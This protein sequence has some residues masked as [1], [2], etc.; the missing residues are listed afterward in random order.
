VSRVPVSVWVL[1][2]AQIV[3]SGVV[4]TDFVAVVDVGG[5]DVAFARGGSGWGTGVRGTC[6]G[7]QRGAG[8]CSEVSWGYWSLQSRSVKQQ[9]CS[10]VAAHIMY[11]LMLGG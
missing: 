7:V 1:D 4:A 2:V 9:T 8:S 5:C 6:W 10:P 3:V 11:Q